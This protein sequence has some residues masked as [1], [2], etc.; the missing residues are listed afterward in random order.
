M[1]RP[2][3]LQLA[4][5]IYL[6]ANAAQKVIAGFAETGQ[7]ER[8]L[9]YAQQSGFQPDYTALLQH[10]VRVNPEKGAEFATSLAKFRRRPAR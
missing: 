9:P 4:L 10:I 3:D 2:H 5:S 6:R 8:I 7:F 1:V